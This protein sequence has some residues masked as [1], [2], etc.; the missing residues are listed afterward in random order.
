MEQEARRFSLNGLA[1]FVPQFIKEILAEMTFQARSSPNIS[2]ISG[3]SCRVSIRSFE[4]IMGSAI[5]R[6]LELNEGK[7]VPRITDIESTFPAIRGKLEP[8]YEAAEKNDEEM[9]KNIV[10]RAI[11]VIFNEHFKLDNLSSIINSFQS[12]VT[13]E[14]SRHLPSK[15]YMD[16][17]DVIPGMRQAVQ[18]L[19]DPDNSSEASS[20]MEFIL[21]GLHLS[22]KLNRK[23]VDKR[24]VY[25]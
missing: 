21:E 7:V 3:V 25:K 20:A 6:S 23:E 18:T 5:Q 22:N 12:G 9:L 13:A 1:M 10:K 4:S 8:E 2:Q 24:I 17:Y 19:V 11:L 14:V 16:G 15:D